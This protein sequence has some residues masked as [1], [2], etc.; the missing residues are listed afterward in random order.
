MT[1]PR[2]CKTCGATKPREAFAKDRGRTT[3]RC[4]ACRAARQRAYYRN[5]S[6][7]R[8]RK[9]DA[10]HREYDRKRYAR[11]KAEKIRNIFGGRDDTGN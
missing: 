4:K 9:L 11:K 5:L 8:L 2:T 1:E 6:I 10:Y 7:E 3:N